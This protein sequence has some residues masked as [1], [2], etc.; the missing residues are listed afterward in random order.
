MEVEQQA[1]DIF[2]NSVQS[3]GDAVAVRS[4]CTGGPCALYLLKNKKGKTSL[5]RGT[6]ELLEHVVCGLKFMN[7]FSCEM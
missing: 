2:M 1:L 5:V 7:Q 4:F 3:R 6:G